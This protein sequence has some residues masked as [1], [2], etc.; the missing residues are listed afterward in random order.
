[1]EWQ[2]YYLIPIL[3]LIAMIVIGV[4]LSGKQESRADFYVADNK[5][6]S[7]VLFS[8]VLATVVG[9]NTYMGF[10]GL[11]YT[12]GFSLIWMLVAASTSYFVLFFISG[13]IRENRR[14]LRCFY[15]ARFDGSQV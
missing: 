7:A 5:M 9:A 15:A 10:S 11:V 3:Y 2:T 1:M 8:T 13:K 6:N 12:G 14:T 4:M